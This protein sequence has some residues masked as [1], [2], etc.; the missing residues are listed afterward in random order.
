M[1]KNNYL[2]Q[3]LFFIILTALEPESV[4]KYKFCNFLFIVKVKYSILAGYL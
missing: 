3:T 4:T 2:K 1:N